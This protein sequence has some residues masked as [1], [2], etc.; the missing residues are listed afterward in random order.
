MRVVCIS[1]ILG[2]GLKLYDYGTSLEAI[3]PGRNHVC[4]RECPNLFFDQDN[5]CAGEKSETGLSGSGAEGYN[6]RLSFFL[7][8]NFLLS[9][10]QLSPNPA[11]L[12]EKVSDRVSPNN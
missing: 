5:R 8:L 3:L 2:A 6:H 10:F 11:F 7:F 4:F 9:A 12:S 1:K